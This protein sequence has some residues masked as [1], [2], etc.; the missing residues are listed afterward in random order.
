MSAKQ[1]I[2]DTETTGLSPDKG[3]RIIEIG[4]I[5]LING[6]ET[7][8]IFHQYINPDRKIPKSATRIHG[9]TADDLQDKPRF[10]DIADDLFN[11]LG[12]G[13]LVIHNAPFDIRFLDHE[14]RLA[15]Y[16]DGLVSSF[17]VLDTLKLARRI[18]PGQRNSL[19][20]LCQRYGVDNSSRGKHGAL[21][22][23]ELLL[24]L[25][26]KFE[27]R[28]SRSQYRG[29]DEP[30]TIGK[31]AITVLVIAAVIALIFWIF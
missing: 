24:K 21:L 1:I 9:I 29:P 4:A 28:R 31:Q 5:E 19:D 14:F 7:G 22:D 3:H 30:P 17:D 12:D 8:R 10:T 15:G 20:A 13:E 6:E 26:V 16:G 23:A 11:F 27:V 18:H 2:L 25:Y